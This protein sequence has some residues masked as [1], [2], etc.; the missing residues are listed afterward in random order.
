MQPVYENGARSFEGFCTPTEPLIKVNDALLPKN[1]TQQDNTRRPQRDTKSL[2]IN[3]LPLLKLSELHKQS[4]SPPRIFSDESKTKNRRSSTQKSSLSSPL[5]KTSLSPRR[6]PTSLKSS[7]QSKSSPDRTSSSSSQG[8]PHSV[9]SD[10]AQESPYNSPRAETYKKPHENIRSPINISIGPHIIQATTNDYHQFAYIDGNKIELH[11][12]EIQNLLVQTIQT[13]RDK[14][15]FFKPQQNVRLHCLNA[16]VKAF[17]SKHMTLEH[18]NATAKIYALKF[19]DDAL[20]SMLLLSGV[21]NNLHTAYQEISNF[22][23]QQ[24]ER[25]DWSTSLCDVL[26][27]LVHAKDLRTFFHFFDEHM[28][29]TDEKASKHTFKTSLKHI[30]IANKQPQ[31]EPDRTLLLHFFGRSN[32]EINITFRQLGEWTDISHHEFLQQK[33]LKYVMQFAPLADKS[34]LLPHRTHRLYQSSACANFM[35]AIS[36]DSIL[37]SLKIS[38][39]MLFDRISINDK[40]CYSCS[41][42]TSALGPSRNSLRE[43]IKLN[44]SLSSLKEDALRFMLIDGESDIDIYCKL[45]TSFSEALTGM[46]PNPCTIIEEAQGFLDLASDSST[47]SAIYGSSRSLRQKA[48]EGDIPYIGLLK[49][50]TSNCNSLGIEYL[51]LLYPVLFGSAYRVE[52]AKKHSCEISIDTAGGYFVTHKH[53]AAIKLKNTSSSLDSMDIEWCVGP[54]LEGF[55]GALT[56]SSLAVHDHSQWK[57]LISVLTTPASLIMGSH[58]KIRYLPADF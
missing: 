7:P 4:E 13:I 51:K 21:L 25:T 53:T 6:S 52:F 37:R 55:E 26:H 39:E 14:N 33:C 40:V 57:N 11:N 56:I 45:F 19:F 31:S 15:C 3:P 23:N 5:I 32:D 12:I 47:D 42:R 41:D 58:S 34:R 1:S 24:K 8:S 38:D 50:M 30:F 22:L 54:T 10:S 28:N 36:L 35:G 27:N 29:T 18:F 48:F 43:S 16:V 17:S 44:L 46:R 2:K 9:C 20:S 49:L